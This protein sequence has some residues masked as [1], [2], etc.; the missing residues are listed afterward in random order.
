MNA[1]TTLICAGSD[2]SP[3]DAMATASASE[4]HDDR[5]EQHHEREHADA[6]REFVEVPGGTLGLGERV[7][8]EQ[9]RHERRAHVDSDVLGDFAHG[10]VDLGA[11]IDAQVAREVV[12]V[13]ARGGRVESNGEYRVHGHNSGAVLSVSARESVPDHDHGNAARAAHE[14]EPRHVANVAAEEGR[15]EEDHDEGP[16]HPVVHHREQQQALD[17]EYAVHQVPGHLGERRL[18]HDEQ[19]HGHRERWCCPRRNY[20]QLEASGQSGGLQ[21][22]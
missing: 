21:L 13:E 4:Q 7:P 17:G 3:N 5:E 10:D 15:R 18:H 16:E 12:D 20:P 2:L 1:P 19:P 6:R 11:R 8:R 9:R 22:L 14:A